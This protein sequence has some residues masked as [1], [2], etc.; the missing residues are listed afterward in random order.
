MQPSIAQYAVSGA[1]SLFSGYF[2]A[3]EQIWLLINRAA[4]LVLVM[5]RRDFPGTP[6]AWPTHHAQQFDRGVDLYHHRRLSGSAR[7]HSCWAKMSLDLQERCISN[8]HAM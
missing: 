2:Q 7:H 6:E 8:C 4:R 5:L 3:T 1:C